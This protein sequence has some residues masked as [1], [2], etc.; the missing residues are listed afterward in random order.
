V[1]VPGEVDKRGADRLFDRLASGE[2]FVPGQIGLPDLQINFNEGMTFWDDERDHPF[3]EIDEVAPVDTLPAGTMVL[4]SMTARD[5]AEAAAGILSWDAEYR[6]DFHG[7][8]AALKTDY[9][10]DPDAFMAKALE[11]MGAS[12]RSP[13]P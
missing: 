7:A 1:A 10:R 12:S 11:R 2:G 3:H 13:E 9:D 6:P 8:M 5:L 4:N